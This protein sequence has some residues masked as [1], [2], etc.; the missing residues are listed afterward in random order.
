MNTSTNP[1]KIVRLKNNPLSFKATNSKQRAFEYLCFRYSLPDDVKS[2]GLRVMEILI[3][4]LIVVTGPSLT[5]RR[6]IGIL[7]II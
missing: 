3:Q 4:L 2:N 1:A 7:G 5:V 6:L